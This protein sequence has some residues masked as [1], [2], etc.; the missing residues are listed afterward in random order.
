MLRQSDEW[1]VD[2]HIERS[3]KRLLSGV[4]NTE[5]SK[6]NISSVTNTE[7]DL[8]NFFP[9]VLCIK[10][11]MTDD[12]GSVFQDDNCSKIYF[13]GWIFLT[14]KMIYFLLSIA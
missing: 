13:I 3:Y 2:R 7:L 8:Y 9:L 4:K 5:T 11:N 6:Q 14:R 10:Q 1:T 12:L